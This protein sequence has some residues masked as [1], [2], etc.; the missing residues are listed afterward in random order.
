M[1][2]PTWVAHPPS[3]SLL[4]GSASPTIEPNVPTVTVNNGDLVNFL[5]YGDSSVEWITKE[6]NKV[7]HTMGTNSTLTIASATYKDT[8]TYQCAYTNSSDRG[9]ASVHLFV[10][11]SYTTSCSVDDIGRFSVMPIKAL[12][13]AVC[14]V[15]GT[16]VE[17][18]MPGSFIPVASH[19]WASLFPPIKCS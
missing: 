1:G 5:C 12:M 8:G 2:I 11:G 15:G 17:N 9:R 16:G 7:V 10:R 19:P 18:R 6:K 4:A 13:E 3:P 14:S